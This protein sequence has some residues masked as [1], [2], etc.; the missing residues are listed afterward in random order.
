MGNIPIPK[1][2]KNNI[3]TY[4]LYVKYTPHAVYYKIKLI[5]LEGNVKR[6]RA[7]FPLEILSKFLVKTYASENSQRN[8]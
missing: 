6:K 2:I 4:Y 1:Q 5:V 8:K 7:F 3:Q